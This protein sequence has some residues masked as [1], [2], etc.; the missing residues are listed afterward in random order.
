MENKPELP[1]GNPM[2]LLSWFLIF[3]KMA[4]ELK[5]LS[6]VLDGGDHHNRF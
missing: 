6:S 1:I 3:K 4:K 2:V 5:L